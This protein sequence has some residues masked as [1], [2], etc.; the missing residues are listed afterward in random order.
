MYRIRMWTCLFWIVQSF[1][2]SGIILFFSSWLIKNK[3]GESC[4]NW[5]TQMFIIVLHKHSK[6]Q[7]IYCSF[8]LLFISNISKITM[9]CQVG[10]Y[11]TV[12]FSLVYKNELILDTF[13]GYCVQTDTNSY[14][15]NLLRHLHKRLF[16]ILLLWLLKDLTMLLKDTL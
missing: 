12:V 11:L 13:V 3:T 10:I 4:P 14:H 16:I 1:R 6:I 7:L 9:I 8:F 15:I 2:D 5:V